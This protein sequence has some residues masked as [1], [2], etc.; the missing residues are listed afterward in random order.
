MLPD[1]FSS[2]E[3]VDNRHHFYA[4]VADAI[5]WL[6]RMAKRAFRPA[7]TLDSEEVPA[8]SCTSPKLARTPRIGRGWW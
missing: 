6:G 8:C 5:A 2:P 1:P 3:W 7:P 4:W